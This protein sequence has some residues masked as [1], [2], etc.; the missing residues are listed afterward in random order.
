M[1]VLPTTPAV[2][3]NSEDPVLLTRRPLCVD[4][5]DELPVMLPKKQ[6]QAVYV[7][8]ISAIFRL[9]L[10]FILPLPYIVRRYRL[11]GNG[12]YNVY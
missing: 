5:D 11:A 12:P 4:D 10:L 3:A 6:I 2:A 8:F 7:F 1:R 9:F